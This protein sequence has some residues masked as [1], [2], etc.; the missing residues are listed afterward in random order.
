MTNYQLWLA[1]QLS[2]RNSCLFIEKLN[3]K[4]RETSA[5][6]PNLPWWLHTCIWGEEVPKESVKNNK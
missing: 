2:L 6:W 4:R 3:W 5:D 1:C